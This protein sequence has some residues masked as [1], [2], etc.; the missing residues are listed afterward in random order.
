M[1]G[2]TPPPGTPPRKRAGR[3]L[4]AGANVPGIVPKPL[5]AVLLAALAAAGYNDLEIAAEFRMNLSQF[6]RHLVLNPEFKRAVLVGRGVLAD[7]LS[8]TV[9]R[10]AVGGDAKAAIAILRAQGFFR[11]D[12]ERPLKN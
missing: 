5:D 7:R 8:G 2:T 4:G 9:F 11:K 1:T 6:S 10:D 12:K 3:P